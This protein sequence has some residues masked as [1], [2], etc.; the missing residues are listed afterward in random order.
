MCA[1][2]FGGPCARLKIEAEKT[3]SRE[4]QPIVQGAVDKC[5]NAYHCNCRKAER[6]PVHCGRTCIG[7]RQE[8][9]CRTITCFRDTVQTGRGPES[10]STRLRVNVSGRLEGRT[11]KVKAISADPS[12][13]RRCHH[14]RCPAALYPAGTGA[15]MCFA[16]TQMSVASIE[17]EY[18]RTP[19]YQ[20]NQQQREQIRVMFPTEALPK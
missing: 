15:A 18:A 3:N 20:V 13:G 14:A 9:L 17:E 4:N 5:D 12:R 7:F 19:A 16:I 11:R 1:V 2:V 6:R 10:P 8:G